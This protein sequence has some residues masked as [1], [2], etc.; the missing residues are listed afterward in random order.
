MLQP[1]NSSSLTE[2]G[3]LDAGLKSLVDPQFLGTS[4]SVDTNI[5][6]LHVKF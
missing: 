1:L 4:D 6:H 2:K 3:Q 5:S